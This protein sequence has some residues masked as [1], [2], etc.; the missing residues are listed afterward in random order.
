M[1]P[2]GYRSGNIFYNCKFIKS[3]SKEARWSLTQITQASAGKK[4]SNL[5]EFFNRKKK[6]IGHARQLITMKRKIDTIIRHI[7][8]NDKIYKDDKVDLLIK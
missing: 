5:K 3:D 8:A 4:S 1:I 7:I 6:P 2:N